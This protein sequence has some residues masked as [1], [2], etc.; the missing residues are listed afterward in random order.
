MA[1]PVMPNR[2][3]A[4]DLQKPFRNVDERNIRRR[5]P[6]DPGIRSAGDVR[7]AGRHDEAAVAA[8]IDAFADPSG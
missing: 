2:F 4:A 7:A 6:L 8:E 1:G 5:T 3:L